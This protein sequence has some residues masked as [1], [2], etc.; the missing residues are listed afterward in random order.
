MRAKRSEIVHT[1]P[2]KGGTPYA[3]RF[4]SANQILL[5]WR[6]GLGRGGPFEPG[7]QL[8]VLTSCAPQLTLGVN[9][10]RFR[11][12]SCIVTLLEPRGPPALWLWP[13]RLYAGFPRG[14][15]DSSRPQAECHRLQRV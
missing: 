15:A 5:L 6:R 3:S 1:S 12:S 2:P 4:E 9:E 7:L 10:T 8:V 11:R 13:L 14:K